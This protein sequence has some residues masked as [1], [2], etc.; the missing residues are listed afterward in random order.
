MLVRLSFSVSLRE[1][2]RGGNAQKV[3][4]D[5]IESSLFREDGDVPVDAGACSRSRCQSQRDE[6]GGR[7]IGCS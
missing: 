2:G 1:A 4:T 5:L 3:H 7:G 6:G